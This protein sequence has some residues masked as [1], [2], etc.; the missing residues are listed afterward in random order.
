MGRCFFV[1]IPTIIVL[2][3]IADH[4]TS[5]TPTHPSAVWILRCRSCYMSP[6]FW[7]SEVTWKGPSNSA[8]AAVI[9]GFIR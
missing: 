2:N 1:S 9:V 6:I 7:G 4:V 8:Q 3:D 5:T